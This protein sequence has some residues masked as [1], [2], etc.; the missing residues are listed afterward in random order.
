MGTK[1]D[2]NSDGIEGE[3]GRCNGSAKVLRV[4][5]KQAFN[6]AM[7]RHRRLSSEN[8]DGKDLSTFEQLA[9]PLSLGRRRS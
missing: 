5:D 2:S 8:V 6:R 4:E 1:A 9:L 7:N 3:I